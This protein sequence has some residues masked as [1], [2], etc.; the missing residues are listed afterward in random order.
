MTAAAGEKKV[1][2]T[3]ATGYIGGRLLHMFEERGMMVRCLARRPEFLRHRAGPKTEV[4][5]G[6]VLE[7][8]SLESALQGIDTAYYLIHS[9]GSAGGFEENDRR[10]AENFAEAAADAGIKR[11]VYLGGLGEPGAL[12]HHLASRQEVGEILRCSGVPTIEFRAS[13]IIGSGSLSFEMIRALTERLP[14]MTTPRWVLQK[15]QPIGIEDVLDYLIQAC[16]IELKESRIFEIGGPERATY[17]DIIREYASLRGLRRW[18]IPVPVLTPRLSGLWLGLVT[19]LYARIGRK[20]VDSLRNE[21]VV[22]NPDALE[23]FPIRPKNLRVSLERALHNE[24]HRFALTRWSDAFSSK[25][26]EIKAGAMKFGNRLI[27]SRSYDVNVKPHAAFEPIMCIGGDRGW[28]AADWLWRIRG[29][30][31]LLAGGVGI[32]RGRRDS[33]DLIPGDTVDFW[34][35]EACD[36][37]RLLRLAAEMKVPGRAWLQ[38]EVEP[39]PHGSRIRQTALFDPVGLAGLLYWYSLYPVHQLV[40]RGMLRGIVKEAQ[41]Q[42]LKE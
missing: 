21:T 23:V 7:A 38:F 19:P 1:L 8:D 33:R 2:L 12:S 29:F 20:L 37:P 5:G 6:D 32:R 27:D 34:R 36:P 10:G 11:I 22:R 16:E 13:I 39:V 4:I 25:G 40:F 18:I 14:L 30:L 41:K 31:D 26:E 42:R 17:A 3:G 28:Y 35:V 24:D 9:M 15:A